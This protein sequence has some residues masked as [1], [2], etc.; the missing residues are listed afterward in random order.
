MAINPMPQAAKV[1]EAYLKNPP[2]DNVVILVL[3]K[4]EAAAKKQ[5]V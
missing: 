2:E 1:L 4:L 3:P 5:M